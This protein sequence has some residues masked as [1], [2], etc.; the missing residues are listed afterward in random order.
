M[1]RTI[2]AYRHS[3]MHT[4]TPGDLLIALY[5]GMA[6][7]CLEAKYAIENG[8]PAAKGVA[9]GRAFDILTELTATLDS[10][11]DANLC[12]ELTK[13]YD[14]WFDRLQ[15]GSISMRPEPVEEVIHHIGNMRNTWQQAITI[16]RREGQRA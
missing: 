8:N 14:Y 6:R 1:Q 4:S 10:R 13:I 7:F 12:L 15:E 2:N 3:Q 11:H 5:D 16:A 9:I